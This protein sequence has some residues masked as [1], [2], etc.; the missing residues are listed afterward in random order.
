MLFVLS[1]RKLQQSL[2]GGSLLYGLLLLL[3]SVSLTNLR[4]GFVNFFLMAVFFFF[5]L[6]YWF[7]KYTVE[8]YLG[9]MEPWILQSD[10]S[11]ELQYSVKLM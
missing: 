9:L 3:N 7:S 11:A 2:E 4:F 6:N 1:L 10:T 5:F 8:K